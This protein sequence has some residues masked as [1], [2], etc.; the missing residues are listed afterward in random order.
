MIT[1]HFWPTPNGHKIS[2]ALEEL[3][4][5]YEVRPVNILAGEQFLPEFL[6][7]SPNNRM[8]AIVDSAGPDGDSYPLFESGAILMY[9][10]EKAG[11]LLPAPTAARYRVLQWLFFQ[12]GNVGPMFG[13]CGHFLGYA[14]ERIPYAIERY[15]RETL[16]LYGVLDRRLAVSEYLADEYSIADI[17]VHPWVKVRWL[18]EIDITQFPHVQR[19]FELIDARPAVQ[20]GY[21]L[22]ADDMK[23]G[24]PTDEAREVLFGQRQFEQR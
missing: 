20:R 2:I 12:V 13:Q 14:P 1:L 11:S 6:A 16:R 9:L 8:P 18:H 4:L 5:T 3:G 17:A 21:A 7:I 19:W 24:S 22:L 10:A 23:I 15:Q